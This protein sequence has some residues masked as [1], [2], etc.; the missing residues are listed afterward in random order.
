VLSYY[1]RQVG[2]VLDWFLFVCV[3]VCL[4]ARLCRNCSTT[5]NKIGLRQASHSSL[6]S[7]KIVK[8]LKFLKNQKSFLNSLN[9][10]WGASWTF[11]KK[12]KTQVILFTVRVRRQSTW[13][14]YWFAPG[15]GDPALASP[16]CQSGQ[17]NIKRYILN[18][19]F[20]CC[21]AIYVIANSCVWTWICP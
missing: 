6:N 7:L 3:V 5:F 21:F 11:C 9:I 10:I 4:L 20:L 19:R 2:F 17:L 18:Y 1:C 8:S 12:T 16:I 14:H 13:T 15:I